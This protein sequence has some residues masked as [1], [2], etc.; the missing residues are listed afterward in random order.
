MF[1]LFAQNVEAIDE[2]GDV[3]GFF[4]PVANMNFIPF[5]VIHRNNFLPMAVCDRALPSTTTST[6]NGQNV[7]KLGFPAQVS[8]FAGPN[9][10]AEVRQ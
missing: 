4:T 5:A 1:G 2:H 3:N 8:I 9:P 7:S 10:L 6:W